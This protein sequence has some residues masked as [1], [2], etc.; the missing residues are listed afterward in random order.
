MRAI[1][2]RAWDAFTKSMMGPKGFGISIRNEQIDHISVRESSGYSS[3]EYGSASR[4]IDQTRYT[5]MQFTGLLDKSGI[6][7]YEGDIVVAWSQ[8]SKGTFEIRW[9][10]EGSPCWIL[11]PA[12]QARQMWHLSGTEHKPGKQFISVGGEISTTK[13][14][15]FYDDGVEIVGNV[16]ENPELLERE[17]KDS[18]APT[19]TR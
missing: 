14:E 3:S 10:Q 6:E 17:E 15:G 11:C 9:R 5:V 7:I 18:A 8:G 19:V 2:F 12:F 16:F 4:P 13:L 1:K